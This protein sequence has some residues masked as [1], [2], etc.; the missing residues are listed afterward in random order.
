ME[1]IKIYLDE[2][3]HTVL[4]KALH[5]HGY[6]AITTVGTGRMS[7]SDADQL[8]FAVLTEKSSFYL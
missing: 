8:E 3:V 5:M 2:D 7:F 4:A 1:A 6:D